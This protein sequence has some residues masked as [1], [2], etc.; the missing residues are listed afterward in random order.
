MKINYTLPGYQTEI[1]SAVGKEV[2]ESFNSPFQDR[3]RAFAPSQPV[4]WSE[5]LGLHQTPPDLAQMNPPPGSASR[6]SSDAAARD[7]QWR[8]MLSRHGGFEEVVNSPEPVRR[9]L[10]LLENYQKESDALASH[11]LPGG[12]H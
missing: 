6:N 3:M 1:G 5:L 4:S 12:D 10:S 9:M 11:T 7:R 2:A 8:Q